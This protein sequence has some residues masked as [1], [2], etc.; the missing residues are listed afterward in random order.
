MPQQHKLLE[1]QLKPLHRPT[2][3][4]R[5]ELNNRQLQS[6]HSNLLSRVNS[7]LKV[8]I[9]SSNQLKILQV[10]LLHIPQLLNQLPR[11]LHRINKLLKRLLNK[12][13]PTSNKFNR[14]D[15]PFQYLLFKPNR[16][17]NWPANLN[18]ILMLCKRLPI[19]KL[20]KQKLAPM[21][22]CWHNKMLKQVSKV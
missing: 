4:L 9:Y 17:Q 6:T 20:I 19:N 7:W 12:L 22:L 18:W 11:Q 14:S 3:Q 5:Q 1:Q 21:L 16:L 15:K 8:Q 13:N 2:K 10:R